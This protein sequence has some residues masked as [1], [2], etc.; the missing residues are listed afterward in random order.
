MEARVPVDVFADV[1]QL[2]V[3]G[4]AKIGD[5]LLAELRE[6]TLDRLHARGLVTSS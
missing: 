4:C 6:R 1:L 2:A 5:V 3:E